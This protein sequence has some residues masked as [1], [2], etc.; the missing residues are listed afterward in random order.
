MDR[1]VRLLGSVDITDSNTS[2]SVN[3]PSG[4]SGD[5][6]FYCS[7]SQDMQ[8]SYYMD[9]KVSLSGRTISWAKMPQGSVIV[10]GVY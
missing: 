9:Q 2:G 3:I 10:F 1:I 8:G 6:F 4:M 5:P 7:Y